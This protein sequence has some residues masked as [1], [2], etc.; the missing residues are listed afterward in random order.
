MCLNR[1]WGKPVLL[2]VGD[3][4]DDHLRNVAAQLFH[5]I[6]FA[7]FCVNMLSMVNWSE[8]KSHFVFVNPS[9]FFFFIWS[10]SPQSRG[11]CLNISFIH[12][13]TQL[14][15]C[16]APLWIKRC[17]ILSYCYSYTLS[18]GWNAALRLKSRAE[19]SSHV[20]FN[21]TRFQLKWRI[22]M[23]HFLLPNASVWCLPQLSKVNPNSEK[24]TSPVSLW[25]FKDQEP[26]KIHS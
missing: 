16:S 13:V 24:F 1:L 19:V 22:L 23:L 15:L 26:Y 4:A 5:G 9:V 2:D 11:C 10:V 8:V 7:S 20:C 17:N 25:R 6:S 12:S 21:N 14:R 18:A 3:M